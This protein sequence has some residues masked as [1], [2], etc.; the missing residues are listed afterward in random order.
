VPSETPITALLSAAGDGDD[1]ARAA[2]WDAVHDELRGMARQRLR[3]E[4][5]GSELQTTVLINEAYLRLVARDER[6]F[7]NRRHFFGAAAESMRRILVDE[8][9]RRCSLK[10]GAGRHTITLSDSGATFEDHPAE[11]LAL[12]EALSELRRRDERK[13]EIVHLRYFAGLTV[14]EVAE[15]LDVS[16]RLVD[17]E[18]RF[19][20]AWLHQAL[21]EA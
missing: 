21:S 2:L 19:A 15:L 6:T 10:R 20:R 1:G 7:R 3:H 9:R 18:W 13:A 4:H 14:A 8:A 5:R 16:P 17:K 12:D 11:L